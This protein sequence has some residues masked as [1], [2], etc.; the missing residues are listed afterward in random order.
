MKSS[1][2]WF[3][4]WLS[5]FA[6]AL[7]LPSCRPLDKTAD[8]LVSSKPAVST[9]TTDT[10]GELAMFAS[11]RE[12][13]KANPK[14]QRMDDVVAWM[15][16]NL[17]PEEAT[18][19]RKDLEGTHKVAQEWKTFTVFVNELGKDRLLGVTKGEFPVGSVLVK[20]K[21]TGD[22]ATTSELLTV[23]VK[24]EK[25]YAPEVGD[26]EFLV[27]D[28]FAKAV[29]RGDN[30]NCVSCHTSVSDNDFVY[31]DYVPK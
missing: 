2:A 19:F 18:K 12:W 11:Y 7:V 10:K 14:P 24:R 5:V 22:D 27:L 8:N 16:R 26:W 29:Q 31:A 15:C 20:E 6:I 23:M 28:G 9:G 25:G 17:T 30:K 13:H 3:V 21:H 4:S 1:K